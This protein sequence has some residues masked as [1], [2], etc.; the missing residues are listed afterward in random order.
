MRHC[1]LKQTN[2]QKRKEKRS[3]N[4]SAAWRPEFSPRSPS[5]NKKIVFWPTHARAHTHNA[6]IHAYTFV[7]NNEH[8]KILNLFLFY[9]YGC[10]A[11]MY[12]CEPCVF[13]ARGGASIIDS[14]KR[15]HGYQES[16]LG[17]LE[18]P[19]NVNCWAISPAPI[20]KNFKN[21]W[22]KSNIQQTICYF[23]ICLFVHLE[24]GSHSLSQPGLVLLIIQRQLVPCGTWSCGTCQ[25]A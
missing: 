14:C 18:E 8:L 5:R 12:L 13:G 15:P 6:C 3:C 20:N 7:I 1:C 23:A 19:S 16:N 21:P 10:F 4:D 17:P 22:C 24:T 25:W 11:C 2:K 9:A